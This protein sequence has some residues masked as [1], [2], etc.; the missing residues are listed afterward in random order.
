MKAWTT[1]C[2]TACATLVLVSAA[3]AQVKTGEQAPGFLLADVNGNAITLEG[4]AGK[5]IVLEWI[6]HD[7]PFV[8][9]HYDSGNMQELQKEYTKQGVIWLAIA[10]S[11][12]GKQGHYS[13]EEHKVIAAQK[14]FSGTALLLDPDGKV[15]RAYGAKTTPH[16]F[17]INPDGKVIYQGAID[18]HPSANKADAKTANNYVRA[19][20]DAALKGG[21]VAVGSAAPY[22]CSV[23]Y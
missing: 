10:S 8:R 19:A 15:G 1:R 14:G 23:K 20:L 21:E 12:P 13:G 7:C 11:A 16:M 5:F 2:A 3:M 17:V 9:K 6:N 4:F 18:D 22:G